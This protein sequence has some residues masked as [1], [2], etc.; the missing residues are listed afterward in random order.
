MERQEV[1]IIYHR[2]P[3]YTGYTEVQIW[4]QAFQ[5]FLAIYSGTQVDCV[6]YAKEELGIVHPKIE[7]Y[8]HE[9]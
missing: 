8:I 2:F 5:K 9:K 4:S 1:K 3:G 7:T 6:R